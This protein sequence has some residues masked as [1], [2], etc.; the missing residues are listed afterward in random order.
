MALTTNGDVVTWGAN[1][2]GQLGNGQFTSSCV[3]APIKLLRHRPVIS[4]ACGEAHTLAVTIGGNVFA[5]GDNSQGQLGVGD[6]TNRL[7]PEMVRSLRNALV[8]DIAAG[9][10]HSMAISPKGWLFAFGSNSHGQLGLGEGGE[11]LRYISVPTVVEKLQP[12]QVLKVSCGSAHTLVIC[13]KKQD[14][15]QEE[16]THTHTHTR[17]VYG[18][19]L[20][21]SGQLGLGHTRNVYNPAR[22]PTTAFV[23]PL[24]GENL[25]PSAVVSGPLA[26]H[27]FVLTN[28][29]SLAPPVL[30]SVD[31]GVIKTFTERSKLGVTVDPLALKNFRER[32]ASWFSSISVL[33]SSFRRQILRDVLQ[34]SDTRGLNISSDIHRHGL[35]LN[36]SEVRS[37]YSTI[38]AADN[39][40]VLA[41]LGRATLSISDKLRE[42]PFDEA[43]NLSVFLIVLENPLL[44]MPSKSH[45]V[46]QR[47]IT[48]ILALPKP[49]R[50]LLFS[51]LKEYQSEY[52]ARIIKV[53]QGYLS[54]TCENLVMN[55]DSSPP[56][57]VLDNLFECNQE[58]KIVPNDLFYNS[59]VLKKYDVYTEWNK[60][61]RS[62]HTAV[63][64]ICAFPFLLPLKTKHELMVAD[65]DISMSTASVQCVNKYIIGPLATNSQ[66]KTPAGVVMEQNLSDGGIHVFFEI[67]VDRSDIVSQALI[68][69]SNALKDDPATLKLRLRYE[70][71]I[72]SCSFFLRLL[73]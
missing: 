5:W 17:Y 8:C 65:Y 26:F 68:Q 64:N 44:L 25:N 33:N 54:F 62:E 24:T 67:A 37:A 48:G 41:T 35:N 4:I 27:S 43:E 2:K 3:P 23:A 1:R 9:K 38:I 32:I 39:D 7:R 60:Y 46:I 40:H 73:L 16:V 29:I 47:V 30:A 52:F 36:L 22:L 55:L 42:C 19:G 10:Q 14:Y 59:T 72:S 12:F 56:V 6:S 63:F 18:M 71:Y 58:A 69:L 50:I 13:T 34:H 11:E 21:S 15:S 66:R 53:L 20:N 61:K 49:S 51:W 28:S 31:I 57:L 45:V 70:M